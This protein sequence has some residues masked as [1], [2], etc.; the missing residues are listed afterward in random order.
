MTV[1]VSG[2]D[3]RGNATAFE[4]EAA[5]AEGGLL[6][7]LRRM[8]RYRRYWG[9]VLDAAG[10]PAEPQALAQVAASNVLVRIGDLVPDTGGATPWRRR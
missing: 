3:Y 4:G 7:L 10:N 5:V 1:R 6:A 9:V 2:H 8:P